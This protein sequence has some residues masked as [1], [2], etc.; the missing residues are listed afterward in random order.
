MPGDTE[1][2]VRSIVTATG[3]G[4]SSGHEV[5]FFDIAKNRPQIIEI[6][7]CGNPREN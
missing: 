7:V 2:G 4:L 6:D 5:I 3:L 1:L